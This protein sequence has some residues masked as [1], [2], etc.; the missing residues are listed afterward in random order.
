MIRFEHVTKRYADGTTAVDDLSFEVAAGELV[1]L[2]GPSGCGKTTTM[3]MVNRLI[4][5]T[6]G[7]IFL[8]GEDISGVDPVELRRRIGYVIQQVGLFPHKTVLDNTATVPHLLG[9]KKSEARL[10]AAELLDLVGLDPKVYGSRYPEQLSGGQRQRVGVARALAADPPVL[11][12]DEP[13]G[14]VDPV[15]RERLQNEFLKLQSQVRKT[16]LFVTH[17]IEEAVRLGDRIAVYGQG[18]IEQ[19]DAPAVVLGA[20]ATPYVADFVGADRGLKRLSVTP[21]EESD[22]EQPPVVHLDDPMRTAAQRLADQGARWAVVLDGEDNLHGWIPAESANQRGKDGT[23]REH[24]RRMEA[25]LPVGASL[26][27]AFSTMLQHDAGWIA[28]I[29]DA[30]EGRFLGV[31]TPARLHEA[32]RR[33]I[34]ADG[35]R[36]S[37]REVE[38]ETVG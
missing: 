4:E 29:D 37:R 22:L 21:I 23:V 30:G 1:T 34:D 28:V 9:V 14:A 5:P 15:V 8:D 2:V 13:F 20:P 11:L 19:F 26:K 38:V 17:D 24:A 18:T 36:V 31:L 6:D 7:R 25:W 16:V 27:Q 33:S 12:M 35:R 32:L 3:K 10:R